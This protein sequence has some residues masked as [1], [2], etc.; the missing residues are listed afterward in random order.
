M[1]E[2]LTDRLAFGLQRA[3][4]VT[5]TTVQCATFAAAR[6]LAEPSHGTL[7][8]IPGRDEVDDG[9]GGVFAWNATSE[10]ADDN[11]NTIKISDVEI[12]RWVRLGSFAGITLTLAADGSL[13]RNIHNVEGGVGRE[14]NI[15]TA[16]GET[17]AAVENTVAVENAKAAGAAG[18]DTTVDT[19]ALQTNTDAAIAT[20]AGYRRGA[21][22][23][24][25]KSGGR[26]V[27]TPDDLR[28]A[29]TV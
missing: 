16:L 12:G 15:V 2:S 10:V 19:T 9:Y 7:L 5:A 24:W 21:R 4:A 23:N 14:A 17:I 13:A 29:W 20:V 18:D 11:N 22:I 25:P 27:L 28:V 8:G 26:Y 1:T 3:G 6:V